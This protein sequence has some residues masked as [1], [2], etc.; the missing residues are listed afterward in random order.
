M[1]VCNKNFD[2]SNELKEMYAALISSRG[3]LKS[4][5]EIHYRAKI[6]EHF[7]LDHGYDTVIGETTEIG[8]HCYILGGVILGARGISSNDNIKWHP[9]IGN[10]VEIGAFSNILGPVNID[11][12]TFIG[13]H[14][15]IYRK[16][17][18]NEKVINQQ[19]K[20]QIATVREQ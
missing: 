16:Y 7:V 18:Q 2:I 17:P 9:T 15:T 20:H 4:G 19:Y 1:F 10:N 6:Q 13:P 5:V 8:N 11:D 3:K 12:N 14:C